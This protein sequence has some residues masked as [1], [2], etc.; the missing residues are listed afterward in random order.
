VEWQSRTVARACGEPLATGVIDIETAVFTAVLPQRDA[1]DFAHRRQGVS[2]L[3]RT[4]L[5]S[6]MRG[7]VKN[8]PK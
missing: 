5:I 6:L 8:Q 1:V 2:S 4:K 3:I 7:S